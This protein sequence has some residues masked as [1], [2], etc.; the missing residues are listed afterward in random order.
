M[1]GED[2]EQT[3]LRLQRR[4][5]PVGGG[6]A[7]WEEAGYRSMALEPSGRAPGRTPR[8]QEPVAQ[9]C[10]GPGWPCAVSPALGQHGLHDMGMDSQRGCSLAA[11]CQPHPGS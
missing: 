4:P 1:R 6:P 10:R 8:P 3:D 7:Q 5:R 2:T 11:A 9:G